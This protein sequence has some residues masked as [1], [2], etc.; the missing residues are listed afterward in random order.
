MTSRSSGA[1]LWIDRDE[2]VRKLA[3][4]YTS[5]PSALIRDRS[6]PHDGAMLFEIVG[7][8][9]KRLKGHYWTTRKTTGEVTLAFRCRERL[10]DL[11]DDFGPHPMVSK[12][13]FMGAQAT[14]A[15]G[16]GAQS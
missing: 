13:V 10:D 9:A 2:Q 1:D 5:V 7:A 3:Y 8:P 16:G 6:Q 11:P 14:I 4:C 12:Q 15:E